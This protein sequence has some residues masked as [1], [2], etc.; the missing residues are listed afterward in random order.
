MKILKKIS[1]A[2]KELSQLRS[3]A[4]SIGFVP[5]MGAIHDGH[6]SL[7]RESQ[8]NCDVTIVSIFVNKKQFNNKNDYEKYPQT[9]KQDIKKLEEENTDF[10]FLP[11]DHEMYPDNDLEINFNIDQLT[12]KLCGQDRPGHFNGVAIIIHKLFNIVKPDLAFFGEKDFQQLQVIRRVNEDL[13]LNI[14]IVGCNTVREESGLA[15]SSRNLRLNEQGKLIAP[16]IYQSLLSMK[17]ELLN[18]DKDTQLILQNY[19]ASLSNLGFGKIDYLE[20]RNEE[21]LELIK[22]YNKDMRAR[23]FI[24]LYVNQIRLIDNIKLYK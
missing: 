12:D 5:T 17:M 21:N 1:E 18:G 3:N 2:Q 13:N 20:I 9:L 6:L 10:L 8:E 14:G 11:D 19:Q 4:E 15:L 23:L 22:N 16:K 24:A 7:I